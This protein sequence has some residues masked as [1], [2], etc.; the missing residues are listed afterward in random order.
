MSSSSEYS[1]EDDASGVMNLAMQQ[2]EAHISAGMADKDSALFSEKKAWST[3]ED[4]ILVSMVERLGTNKWASIAEAIIT[5]VPGVKRTGKQCRER[6]HNH[7]DPNVVKSTLSPEEIIIITTSHE[8]LGNKWADIAKR[9]PGRNANQIKNYWYS[10]LRRNSRKSGGGNG[11][12]GDASVYKSH[13]PAKNKG[14]TTNK[15]SIPIIKSKKIKGEIDILAMSSGPIEDE[16]D[17]DSSS[18]YA[19]PRSIEPTDVNKTSIIIDS[20]TDLINS[21]DFTRNDEDDKN[22]NNNPTI[23]A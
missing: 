9:L 13:R 23:V 8:E 5:Q 14:I 21:E 6:W 10:F 11:G 22:E 3:D 2:V 19:I 17:S 16:S 4:A 1:D 7:L 15:K 18:E 12:A 20:S